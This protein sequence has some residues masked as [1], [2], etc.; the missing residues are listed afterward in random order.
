[1]HAGPSKA[2]IAPL[3]PLPQAAKGVSQQRVSKNW[4]RKNISSY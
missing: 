3:I 4:A 1:M 2:E